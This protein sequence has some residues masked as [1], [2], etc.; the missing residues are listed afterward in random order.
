MKVGHL[1]EIASELTELRSE[2]NF[3]NNKLIEDTRGAGATSADAYLF[4]ALLCGAVSPLISAFK[5]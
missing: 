2:Q 1:W 5:M 3:S 4:V